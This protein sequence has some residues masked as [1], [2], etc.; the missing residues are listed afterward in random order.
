MQHSKQKQTIVFITQYVTTYANPPDLRKTS[1][2][3]MYMMSQENTIQCSNCKCWKDKIDF[4]GKNGNIVKR[5][6]V[7]R[8]KD[9]RHKQKDGVRQKRNERQREKRYDIAWREKQRNNNVEEF[10]AK[11]AKAAKLWRDNNKE[12][13]SQW[14]KNNVA[15]RTGS[16]KQQAIVKGI[17]WNPEMSDGI[18]ES[19]VT[20]ACYYCN[21]NVSKVSGLNGIDRMDNAKGYSISNCVSCCKVCNF[22]KKSLDAHTFIE[23]CKHISKLHGSCGTLSNTIWPDCKVSSFK[24]YQSRAMK[25]KIIFEMSESDFRLITSMPCVYCHKPTSLSHTNGIDRKDNNLGYV[26]ENITSCCSQCNQ[27][28]GKMSYDEFIDHCKK[29][30][31]HMIEFPAKLPNMETCLHVITR[32]RHT[33]TPSPIE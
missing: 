15:T 26:H 17:P 31:H 10:L 30:A 20:S 32:R 23:R 21:T 24:A 13:L 22:V 14:R 9:A 28:K 3:S 1:Y 2:M 8:E 6:V 4:I 27:M 7:C 19:L 18:C 5:C 33:S 12:H 29:V 11:N 16:I 25:K